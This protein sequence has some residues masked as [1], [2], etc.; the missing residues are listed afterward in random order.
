L[1]NPGDRVAKI[2]DHHEVVRRRRGFG[3]FLGAEE[4]GAREGG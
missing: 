3:R 4:D 2:G 1:E